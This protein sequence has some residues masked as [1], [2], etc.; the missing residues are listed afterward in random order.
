MDWRLKDEIPAE[1]ASISDLI[2]GD[3][4]AVTELDL[5]RKG[6]RRLPDDL[7]RLRN[8]RKL[9]VSGND[10]TALPAEMGQLSTLEDLDIAATKITSLPLSLISLPIRILFLSHL[11][12]NAQAILPHW[13]L[14]ILK[15]Y[16]MP[17]GEIDRTLALAPATARLALV[18]N[19]LTTL[20][21]SVGQLDLDWLIATGQSFSYFPD[22]RA[23]SRLQHLDLNIDSLTAVPDWIGD[24]TTLQEL[25]LSGNNITTL[26]R[27]LAALGDDLDLNLS[28]NP[29]TPPLDAL[30]KQGTPALFAHLREPPA[31]PAPDPA[32]TAAA[33]P[34]QRLA[35]VRTQVIDDRLVP[36]PADMST[37][38]DSPELQAMHG[39]TLDWARQTAERS[40]N[41]PLLGR[42]VG[43]CVSL[44]GET[45][46]AL[47][48]LPLAFATDRLGQVLE[49]YAQ[50]GDDPLS[51]EQRGMCNALIGNIKMLLNWTEA[52]KD[53]KRKSQDPV[54]AE[55]TAQVQ[56]MLNSVATAAAAQTK[57]V[58]PALPP[59][60]SD[61]AE[62][63]RAGQSAEMVHGAMDGLNNVLASMARQSLLKL[64]DKDKEEIRKT[65]V[66][67][68]TRFTLTVGGSL[69]L[70]A[71][72][73]IL[74]H[75]PDLM[76]LAHALPMDYGW[77]RQ[78][79]A[80][81]RGMIAG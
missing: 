53:Y 4:E 46:H 11:P 70:V 71:A 59:I 3:L 42:M 51:A 79:I 13:P 10:L 34:E 64:T 60:L 29:L 75:S 21:D 78:V 22:L 47:Q 69:A 38:V 57:A 18:N 35:P 63:A 54:T 43:R 49:A 37:E 65:V 36:L 52:W 61:L 24:L 32:A 5:A 67:S 74:T 44:L 8:L 50:D 1:P 20:P 7:G 62:A 73:F 9:E 25:N 12:D 40:G 6:L 27:H 2:D 41:H 48:V 45:V 14:R 76:A 81:L 56:A 39:E 77:L 30:A 58:D 23:C 19:G 31:E 80:A 72:A 15:L 55:A 66:Q 68:A 33:V 26:P 17:A 28:D 16:S